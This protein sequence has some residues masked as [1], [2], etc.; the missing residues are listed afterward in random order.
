[1]I[2]VATKPIKPYV[3]IR[4]PGSKSYTHR[5]L[6]AAALSDGPCRIVNPLRSQ[7]TRLTI[8][9]LRQLGIKIEDSGHDVLIQGARGRFKASRD[10]IFLGNSGTSMRL[11][12]GLVMLGQGRYRLTGVERM[13]QRPIQALI[14]S[15]RL[16]GVTA[17][18]EN[19]DGCPPLIVE[20]G[21]RSGGRTRIDC[22]TSS[23]YLSSLLLA[24]P[25][26]DRGLIVEVV[27]RPVSKPYID[28]TVGVMTTCGIR[29]Q[30]WDYERF[31]IAGGQTY[32]SGTYAVE[33]DASQAGYFWA[34]AAITGNSVKVRGI[35]SASRQGDVGL[36]DIFGRMG[37]RVDYDPDGITVTGGP[38]TAVDVDMGHLPDMV[39]TLAVAAAFARGTTV[40]RN[41]AHLKVK[42]SDRLATVARELG[43]MGISTHTGADELRIEGGKPR[44]AVI[45]TYDDHRIA[46]SFGVA[47]LSVPGVTITDEGCVDKS[48]PDFWQVLEA[49]YQ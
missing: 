48:F 13:C 41:V 34:A 46:M 5:W 17:F 45:D 15:L 29:M 35:T 18:A 20:G 22:T 25:C 6:I 24:A 4:V 28:M 32:R 30:R 40:I 39:P 36:A 26:L 33:P 47:G 2:T 43:K 21:R 14:D 10:P 8:E 31:E 27:D 9:A 16:L 44:S 19:D 12:G 49:L 38:L 11:L 1:M 3:E 37:C 42:E 7:D 23:Q